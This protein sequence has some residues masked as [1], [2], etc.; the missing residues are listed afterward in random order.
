MS[1]QSRLNKEAKYQYNR[2]EKDIKMQVAPLEYYS[3][4][5]EGNIIFNEVQSGEGITNRPIMREILK[6]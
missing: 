3:Q 5:K 1:L 4:K 2:M 6:N